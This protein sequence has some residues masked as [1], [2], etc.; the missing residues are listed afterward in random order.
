MSTN[1][2]DVLSPIFER[3][4]PLVIC[5]I[6]YG[7]L[8]HVPVLKAVNT[9]TGAA[10]IPAGRLFSDLLFAS[11]VLARLV[12]QVVASNLVE[13]GLHGDVAGGISN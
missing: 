4:D 6:T 1:A 3:S 2:E 7:C 5:L 12:R 11:L 13:V 9:A 10:L 8:H